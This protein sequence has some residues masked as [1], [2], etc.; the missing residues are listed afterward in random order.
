MLETGRTA[1]G[2]W[3]RSDDITPFTP[4]EIKAAPIDP[5]TQAANVQVDALNNA[6]PLFDPYRQAGLQGLQG[7]QQ[8]STA[9]GLDE[10]LQQIM[11]GDLFGS[12]VDERTR[13]VEGMLGSGG[14]SRSGAAIEEG[15][16]IPTDIAMMLEG[17]LSGRQGALADSGYVATSEI[18]GLTSQVGEAIASGI[19]GR[20]AQNSAN[21]ANKQTNQSNLL[22]SIAG[23]LGM[24]FSDP[25]LKTNV[26]GNGKIGPLTLV[27]W[28]WIPET[29]GTIVENMPTIGF[30]STEIKEH[31]PEYVSE[32]GG[33]DI[34]DY[35][36]LLGRLEETCL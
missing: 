14:L 36:G 22:G 30:M 26:T 20:E 6:I 12:L 16:K 8:G 27:E 1:T 11:G 23:G 17:I 2:T 13:S 34:I 19:L 33:Y 18:G 15:A 31:Y 29:K 24:A 21:K 32:F 35:P 25:R 28:D 4:S 9:Q 3:G 10:I 5:F 7:Y